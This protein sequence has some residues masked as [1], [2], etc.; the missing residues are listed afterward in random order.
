MNGWENPVSSKL[1]ELRDQR[2]QLW[3]KEC[4][5]I[6]TT[7]MKRR[8]SSS[9]SCSSESCKM[10]VVTRSWKAFVLQKCLC[11]PS[12]ALVARWAPKMRLACRRVAIQEGRAYQ[13]MDN[14]NTKPSVPK[15]RPVKCFGGPRE[16]GD[17]LK[18][19]SRQFKTYTC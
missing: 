13:Y 3:A 10:N 14:L 8:R 12:T 5:G 9:S 19:E 1:D 4:V 15:R 17:D 2:S 18:P 7:M 16:G 11:K 6:I